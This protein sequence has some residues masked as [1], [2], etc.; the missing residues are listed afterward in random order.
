MI[1]SVEIDSDKGFRTQM[2][3]GRISVFGTAKKQSE[4]IAKEYA[5]QTKSEAGHVA[6]VGDGEIQ[7]YWV[8]NKSIFW[9]ESQ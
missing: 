2:M 3:D 1:F 8:W 4:K 9:W 6:L 7:G 5:E